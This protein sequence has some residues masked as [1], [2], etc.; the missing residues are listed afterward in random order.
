[1]NQSSKSE[2]LSLAP[3]VLTQAVLIHAVLTHAASARN[4]R[5]NLDFKSGFNT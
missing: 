1:M 5:N 3:V 4:D 2:F